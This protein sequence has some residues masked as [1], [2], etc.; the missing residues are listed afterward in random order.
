MANREACELYIEQE[1]KDGLAQGKKPYSI[2]KEL[3]GWVEKVFEVTIKPRTIEQ[4]ARRIDATNVAKKS[5]PP[6]NITHSAPDIIKD[7]KPQGGG[8][9]ENAGRPKVATPPQGCTK[10]IE[11]E[12]PKQVA[13]D[14]V[15]NGI[16]TDAALKVV[17][18][19]ISPA[20]I[21]ALA[22]R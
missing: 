1:I 14:V 21:F 15:K 2:G 13:P 9:R 11:P 6:E 3:S 22:A 18:W 12:K 20:S 4:R 5:Q 10:L 8:V 7:R 19:P 17:G 16:W